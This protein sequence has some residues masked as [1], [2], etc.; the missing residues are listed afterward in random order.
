M[1]HR[2]ELSDSQWGRIRRFFPH[3]TH[4]HQRGRPWEPHRRIVNGILWILHTGAPWRDVPARYGPW[5]TVYGRFRR[6]R[7]DGTWARIVTRLLGRLE[8]RG[9]VGHQLWCVDGTIVRG[10]RAA[11]G[12]ARTPR[13]P[14][15]LRGPKSV[16][17]LEPA[18]HGLGYSRGG[19]TTKVH[20]LCDSRGIVLGIHVT[21]GQR[22]ESRAFVP[23]M[24]HVYL[25]HPR[26][27]RTWPEQMAGDKGYSYPHIRRWMNRHG[28]QSIIPTRSN[29][30]RDDSFDKNAYRKRNIIERVVGWFKDYRRLGTRYE[31]LAVNYVAFWIVAMIAKLLQLR[32]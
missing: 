4:H 28:I 9:Q 19:F 26:G 14:P 5:Q 22:H 13:A 32:L 8:R 30:V 12:A 6:W 2:Y 16:V 21:P 31:K 24:A 17:V 23:L 11:G 15:R 25:P 20:L 10:S 1:C 29:Q 7:Q 27:S 3:R 18:D